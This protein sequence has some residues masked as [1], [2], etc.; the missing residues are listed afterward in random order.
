ILRDAF[1]SDGMASLPSAVSQGGPGAPAVGP[2]WGRRRSEI[3]LPHVR[4]AGGRS[5]ALSF[6]P[7]TSRTSL[8]SKG[9]GGRQLAPP[10]VPTA[11]AIGNAAGHLHLPAQRRPG[12]ATGGPAARETQGTTSQSVASL[13]RAA[14]VL[15]ERIHRRLAHLAPRRP[16]RGRLP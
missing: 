1:V 4:R 7:V 12:S 16:V 15:D 8:P 14:Q 6:R 11:H 3:E 13:P 5:Q 10:A 9:A 2:N